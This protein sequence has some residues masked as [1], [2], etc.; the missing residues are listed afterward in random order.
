MQL[1]KRR[2]QRREKEEKKVIVVTEFFTH[3]ETMHF[4]DN[5]SENGS[6]LEN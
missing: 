1:F 2:K 4:L 3:L 6:F 5:E